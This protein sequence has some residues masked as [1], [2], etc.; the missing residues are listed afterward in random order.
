MSSIAERAKAFGGGGSLGSKS[1]S[2]TSAKPKASKKFKAVE[3]SRCAV[4]AKTVYQNDAKETLDSKQY[5]K[6]CF[7]CADCQCQL[8]MAKVCVLGDEL[9]CKVH[10][11]QRFKKE[12][13]YGGG[14]K[15]KN[16]PNAEESG[17][18]FFRVTQG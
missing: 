8:T 4:C 1:A 14:D 5:H 18:K 2:V 13:K 12:G 17:A 9:L 15:F 3:P 16:Q 11:E 7:K 6:A 10:N